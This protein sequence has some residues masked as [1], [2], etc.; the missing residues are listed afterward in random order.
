MSL[1]SK[2]G[3]I[4]EDVVDVIKTN[5]VF[6]NTTNVPNV[7]DSGLSFER[8]TEKK[9][10][11]INTCVL[12]VDIRNSVKLN[13][14]HDSQTM[15][16]V[17]TA[18][19]KAVLKIAQYHHGFVR[20]IIGDRVM[21]VFP[22]KKCYTNAVKCAISINHISKK[23][24]TEKFESVNFSCGIGIDFGELKVIKVG[25]ERKG[26]ERGENMNL[27]WVGYPANLASRLTDLANKEIVETVFEVTR[28][29]R[30]PKSI[31][32]FS[33]FRPNND[34][35]NFQLRSGISQKYDSKAPLYLNSVETV[36]MSLEEFAKNIT[37]H[38]DGELDLSGGKFISFSKKKNK[39]KFRKIL[40]TEK[41]F[42]GYKKANPDCNSIKKNDWKL[43]GYNFKNIKSKVYEG[44]FT[45]KIGK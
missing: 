23:I 13:E 18:F 30:N 22:E 17:Y 26:T 7:E 39:T 4:E 28:N 44:S 19:I 1:I 14:K 32:K 6:T 21:I 2:L 36:E 12:F 8:S 16:K 42:I 29:P 34:T 41:V 5:F 20:N 15:G 25:I 33:N 38:R 9:G 10:K 43:S 40:I 27:V 24:I 37:N 45:W 31:L 35:P 11:K 3:E